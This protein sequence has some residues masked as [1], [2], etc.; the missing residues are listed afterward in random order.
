MTEAPQTD[1]PDKVGVVGLGRMGRAMVHRL[2]AESVDV[3]VWNRTLSVA[4]EIAASTGA[5][6][7]GTAREAAA[8]PIVLQ[9]L[10]DDAAV[11]A[12]ATGPEGVVAGLRPGAVLVET[13]TVDP[14][15]IVT[16]AAAVEEAGASLLAAPVSGSVPA[17]LAGSL[18]IMVG[19]RPESLERARGVLST[20]GDRIFHLGPSGAGAAMKLAVNGVVHA[21]NIGLAEALVMAERCA[22]DRETAWDVLTAS[23]AGAPFVAYKRAAFMDPEGTPPAFSIELVEKDLRLI[24]GLAT[25]LGLEATQV[26]VNHAIAERAV[27]EG[28]GARDMSWIA[29]LLR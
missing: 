1:R 19:G 14:G 23:V 24:A 8:S 2:R 17:V 29:Q 10:A 28:H 6:V 20:I 21:L 4:E 5:R 7:A 9:S 12:A 25:R 26:G 15:T 18:M 16:L 13:S 11:L 27:G 3:V 22:V